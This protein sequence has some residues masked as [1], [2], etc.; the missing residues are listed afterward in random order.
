MI[1]FVTAFNSEKAKLINKRTFAKS[2]WAFIVLSLVMVLYGV[3]MLS[4]DV[5]IGVTL[6]VV[7]VL[8]YPL[9]RLI[10]FFL[11]RKQNQSMSIMSEQT[12]ETYQFDDEYIVITQHQGRD[13]QAVTRATYNYL[14]SAEETADCYYLYISKMQ[15]HV[16]PKRD[17]V[18]GSLQEMNDLLARKLGDKFKCKK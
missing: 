1:K 4:D 15:C 5:L 6:I 17:L 18:E 8:F 11:Q 10:T 3:V 14:Y 12:E 2:L 13:F 9:V 7:G 16:L